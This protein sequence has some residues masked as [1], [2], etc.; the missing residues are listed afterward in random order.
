MDQRDRFIDFEIKR[1]VLSC[2]CTK[3][4]HRMVTMDCVVQCRSVSQLKSETLLPVVGDRWPLQSV[5]VPTKVLQ[6]VQGD[7]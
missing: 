5:T 2:L 1:Q 6:G 4:V 7:G 3:D